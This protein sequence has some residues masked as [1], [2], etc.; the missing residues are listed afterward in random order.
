[1]DARGSYGKRIGDRLLS[2][3]GT[4]SQ[5]TEGPSSYRATS[6]LPASTPQT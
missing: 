4:L 6:P 3:F 5:S 2:W 1:M